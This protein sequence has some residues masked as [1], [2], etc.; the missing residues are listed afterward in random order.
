MATTPATTRTR[1]LMR[2][3]DWAWLGYNSLLLVVAMV[4]LWTDLLP[5]TWTTLA[6]FLGAFFLGMAGFAVWIGID[7]HRDSK[8]AKR[9]QE[10]ADQAYPAYLHAL[11]DAGS[12]VVEVYDGDG[13][14]AFNINGHPDQRLGIRRIKD[15]VV[16]SF[17][18]DEAQSAALAATH[19]LTAD[20]QSVMKL[21]ELSTD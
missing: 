5:S 20:Q 11:R 16:V 18:G 14:T 3:F 8:A 7:A 15:E 21:A 13:V 9:R 4:A 10:L 2:A 6:W 12:H 19:T 1:P 17:A